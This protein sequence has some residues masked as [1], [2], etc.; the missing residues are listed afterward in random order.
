[1]FQSREHALTR[2]SDGSAT[3]TNDRK[4]RLSIAKMNFYLNWNGLKAD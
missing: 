1:M 2:L 3:K 4:S